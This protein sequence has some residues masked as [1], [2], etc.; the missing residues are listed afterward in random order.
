METNLCNNCGAEVLVVED[1]EGNLV[2]LVGP[3]QQR[4]PVVVGRQRNREPS[5]DFYR[6]KEQEEPRYELRNVL[7]IHECGGVR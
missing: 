1:A 3:D 4:A 7:V 6:V 2:F 5:K